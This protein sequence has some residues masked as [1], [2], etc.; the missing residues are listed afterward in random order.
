MSDPILNRYSVRKFNDEP[1]SEA[2]I[3]KLVAAFQAAP[4]GMHQMDVLRG[5][6]VTDDQLKQTIAD[7]NNNACYG[8]PL[9]FVLAAKH[10]SEF[11]ERDASVAAENI[12]VEA[13]SLGLGSVYVMGGAVKLNQQPEVLQQLDLPT[14]FDVEVIVAVGKAAVEP[15]HEDRSQRYQLIRK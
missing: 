8:A 9:L 3:E 13:T 2:A 5:V 1:V 10:D 15:E 4:C 11:A 12:M 6:V 7:A 14:G